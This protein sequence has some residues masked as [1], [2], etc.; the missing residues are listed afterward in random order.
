MFGESETLN[1][2]VSTYCWAVTTLAHPS[3]SLLLLLLLNKWQTDREG[4]A[5]TD[6]GEFLSLVLGWVLDFILC[7]IC[8]NNRKNNHVLK[9]CSSRI[10]RTDM[11]VGFLN[12]HKIFTTDALQHYLLVNK[13]SKLK[14]YLLFV[15]FV[16]SSGFH[17]K[18]AVKWSESKE[19]VA[20]FSALKSQH[21]N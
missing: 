8:A 6:V 10:R 9:I 18:M 5:T 19:A 1:C 4:R 2:E 3:V 12:C 14:F 20:K 17:Q 7:L 21:T 15:L 16:E 11:V 13:K